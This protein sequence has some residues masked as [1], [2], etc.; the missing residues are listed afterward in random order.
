MTD[1]TAFLG[2]RRLA[3]GP[4]PEVAA[5]VR[6]ALDADPEAQVLAFDDA[7]GRVVD[8]DLR[9]TPE[10]VH[11]RH[12]PARGRGRPKLGVSAREVTLLPRH[13]DWLASRRGGASA[14]L[15]ALVEAAMAADPEA[16]GRAG[17][18]AAYRFLQAL[19]GDLP[20]YEDAIRAL[21]AGDAAAFEARLS[22]W[23]PDVHGHAWRLAYGEAASRG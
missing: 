17:R 11:D 10:E 16:A 22:A 18:E 12:G 9:G 3:S 8:L 21:F 5:E 6:R 2:L 13:W 15:R 20:G 14:A 19:A 7:D 23:P 1:A 4:L